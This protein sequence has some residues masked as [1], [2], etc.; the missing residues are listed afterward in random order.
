MLCLR[1]KKHSHS[2]SYECPVCNHFPG[3]N[4]SMKKTFVYFTGKCM[5]LPSLSGQSTEKPL[6]GVFCED[7]PL[8]NVRERSIILNY[9]S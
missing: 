2:I 9:Y 4:Q 8:T 5:R 7:M 1:L 3:K 6:Q